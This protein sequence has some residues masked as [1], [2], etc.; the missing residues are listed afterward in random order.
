M[1]YS[2]DGFA[3]GIRKVGH[4]YHCV[5][6]ECEHQLSFSSHGGQGQSFYSINSNGLHEGSCP[7]ETG[8]LW[9]FWDFNVFSHLHQSLEWVC[10]TFENGAYLSLHIL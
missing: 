7:K 4:P 1:N 8:A 9:I 3:F 10:L 5:R 6:P 2:V